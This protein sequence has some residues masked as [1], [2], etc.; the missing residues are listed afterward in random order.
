MPVLLHSLVVIADGT[1]SHEV[2]MI[3]IR[4]AIMGEVMAGAGSNHGDE[5]EGCKLRHRA[6][7]ALTDHHVK[8]LGDIGPVKV[9]MVDHIIMIPVLNL[10]QERNELVKVE[11]D[12]WGRE[13]AQVGHHL[14]DDDDEGVFS[15]DFIANFKAIEVKTVYCTQNLRIGSEIILHG[16]YGGLIQ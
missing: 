14:V 1:L 9:V 6:E 7:P 2:Y 10:A 16:I 5:V 11:L 13:I 8:H 15:T 12:S 3:D 4:L